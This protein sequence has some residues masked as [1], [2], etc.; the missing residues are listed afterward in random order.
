M[1]W[2]NNLLSKLISL[3]IYIG[4]NIKQYVMSTNRQTCEVLLF[5]VILIMKDDLEKVDN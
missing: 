2:K 5:Q 1:N 4:T 3:Q